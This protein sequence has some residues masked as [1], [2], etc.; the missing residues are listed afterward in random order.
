MRVSRDGSLLHHQQ[1]QQES[2][3]KQSS[4]FIANC[5]STSA[6]VCNSL[7]HWGSKSRLETE[8]HIR[9]NFTVFRPSAV[10]TI[11]LCKVCPFHIKRKPHNQLTHSK[12]ILYI[13]INI[14]HFKQVIDFHA[15]GEMYKRTERNPKVNQLC[16]L[17][18]LFS[19]LCFFLGSWISVSP[20]SSCFSSS[21]SSSAPSCFP[22]PSCEC[23]MWVS[24][25]YTWYLCWKLK[26]VKSSSCLKY[27]IGVWQPSLTNLLIYFLPHILDP[28][29]N[30]ISVSV[31]FAFFGFAFPI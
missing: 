25:A 11:R 27:S 19:F 30:H 24:C 14:F 15:C 16:C 26:A 2:K 10:F 23:G 31:C 21:I 4:K 12:T 29:L 3:L 28:K 6:K 5:H 7:W 8:K 22:M 9:H 1:V 20:P 17:F 13:Y 18:R